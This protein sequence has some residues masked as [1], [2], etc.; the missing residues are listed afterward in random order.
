MVT[1]GADG[2]VGVALAPATGNGVSLNRY[3]AFNVAPPGVQLDN[4]TTAART[5]VNEVTGPN[6]NPDRGAARGAG[7]ARPM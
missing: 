6:R 5:I 3:D 7:P 1:L 2:S 4:R